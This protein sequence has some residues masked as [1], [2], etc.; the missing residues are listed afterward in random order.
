MKKELTIVFKD[1]G[2]K[3]RHAD[4]R[5][6]MSTKISSNRMFVVSTPV[7]ISKCIKIY[8]E[9]VTHLWHCRY[10]HLSFKGLDTLI[11]KDVVKG[12]PNLKDQK[13][14]CSDFV[15]VKKHREAIPK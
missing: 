13:V 3:V 1:R 8:S 7:F 4:I 10:G 9:N 6:I 11:K 12:M 5:L 14:T 15:M 2:C